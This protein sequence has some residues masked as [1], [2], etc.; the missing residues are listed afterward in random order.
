MARSLLPGAPGAHTNSRAGVGPKLVALRERESTSR[1]EKESRGK[2]L[3]VEPNTGLTRR[4]PRG[5]FQH[6]FAPVGRAF[7]KMEL[8]EPVTGFS[9]RVTL[10]PS[11]SGWAYGHPDLPGTVQWCPW[12][13][14]SP[15][16]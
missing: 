7:S 2:G 11:R 3:S 16:P 12:P 15:S 9:H 6:F 10:C 8:Q 5:G 14:S 4:T 1:E 13:L